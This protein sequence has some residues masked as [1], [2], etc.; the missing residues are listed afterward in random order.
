M[1]AAP[2]VAVVALLATATGAEAHSLTSSTI[3][4]HVADT[5][6]DATV[7]VALETLEDAVGS[8]DTTVLA[9]YLADHLAVTGADGSTWAETWTSPTVETVDGIESLSVDVA[10]ATD[11]TSGFVLDY[12]GVI[13]SVDAHEAVVVLTDAAGDVSTAGVITADQ[14]TLAI[15]DASSAGAWDM[16]GYGFHHVLEGADHLLFLTSLLLTGPL[17]VSAG[18]W[19]RRSGPG[20]LRASLRDVLGIVTAFTLGHSATLIAASL[21]WISPP[22]ALV[23]ILVSASVGVAA[24]HALR[25][26]VRGGERLIAVGF[27]LVHGLAFAGILTT[28]GLSGSTS[29]LNLLAF[30][31]GVELAQ[32]AAVACVFPSLYVLSRSRWA[33]ATRVAIAG[34]ALLAATCWV[35]DR[36]GLLAN[37][38]AG[39]ETTLVAH[40]PYV[41]GALAVL[42]TAAHLVTRR[43]VIDRESAESVG[44]GTPILGP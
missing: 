3:S 35:L 21:G 20:S 29:V 12:D 30:N 23:E 22:T 25:P 16:I 15:G 44:A 26:L 33:V 1:V 36:T 13:E 7:T 4:L 10:F 41:V 34:T 27:G 28:L 39:V 37:P 6:A 43:Q 9:D 38:L 24:V 5:S 32:L 31:V 14:P 2:L 17:V 8:T 42:A 11:D 40:L 19:V 18:R